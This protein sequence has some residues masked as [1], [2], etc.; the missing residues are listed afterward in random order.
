MS[1]TQKTID[2][3]LAYNA[4]LIERVDIT[5]ELAIGKVAMDQGPAPNFI[6]GQFA[7]LGLPLRDD[8]LTDAQRERALKRGK[9]ALVRRA[10]S[11]A[12]SPSTRDHLEFYLTL[13][14]HGKLTTR[15][16]SLEAGQQLYMSES[17]RGHFTLEPVPSDVDIVM[18]ATGTGLA[19][20]L[21]MLRM[22]HNQNRWRR[23][24][25]IHATRVAADLGYRDELESLAKD[26]ASIFYLP[27]VTREPEDGGWT[28]HRGRPQALLEDGQLEKLTGI[29]LN[30]DQCHIMLCGNPL[31]ID[32]IETLSREHGYTQ[33]KK[34]QPGSLHFERYW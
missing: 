26:D 4:R 8:E 32:Q 25:L 9:P 23:V 30:P 33:H 31:M 28:G 29:T 12:S 18:V 20:F 5:D 15:L 7:E 17:A 1:E 21:S 10:Y 3:S 19:P 2:E 6:A 13:V 24:A 11:I 27:T 14:K 22:Y 34:K 16:W